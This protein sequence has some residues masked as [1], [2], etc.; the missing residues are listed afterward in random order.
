MNSHKLIICCLIL[1]AASISVWSQNIIRGPY[2]Q[3]G[4]STS[5]T[6]KWRTDAATNSKI[7]YGAI[8][9]QL[10]DSLSQD[11]K[12]VDHELVLSGLIP[13]TKY[14]YAVGD[15]SGQMVGNDAEHSFI[16]AP[17]TGAEQFMRLWVLG[18]CGT[19]DEKQRAVRD[20]YYNYVGEEHTD[21]ILLLGDNAYPDGKDKEYQKA[22]FEDMY[23][24]KL[25]NTHLWSCPGNHDYRS[26][27]A[28]DQSGPYFDIFS[29]PTNAEAGGLASGTEAY[30]SFDYG[31]LHVVSLD[32]HDSGRDPGDPM[33]VWL[34][35]DLAATN[36]TWIIVIF[37]HPPYSKGS[38][39]SDAEN[40]L[41]DMRENV[42]PIL[43]DYGVDLVLNGHSHG[44]E[45]SKLINGHYGKSSTYDPAL[46]DVD[47]GNGRIEGTG[48]YF[49]DPN[50]ENPNLGAVYTVT[51]SAGKLSRGS[52]D[53]P[54]MVENI[55]ELGSSIIEIEKN[56]LD[57]KFL[58]S[59][60]AV[61]DYFTI[62]KSYNGE[63]PSAS[64]VSPGSGTRF[65][66]PQ[67]ISIEA[68]ANDTDG[69]V[70]QVDFF[71]DGASVGVDSV[72]P[73]AV[74]WLIPEN[75]NYILSVKATDDSG[76][77]SASVPVVITVG[78]ALVN[79]QVAADS[80]D[81][82]E[83]KPD[84]DVSLSSSD[85]ELARDNGN[86]GRDQIVGVRFNQ[87]SVPQGATIVKAH[88]QFTV[89]EKS[90]GVSSID[91]SG[92]A[93]DNAKT[94][95][96][97]AFNISSRPQ[98]AASV[99][100]VISDW[101]STNEAGTDQQSP[102]LSSIVQEIV[103]RPGWLSGA[104]M[105]FFLEGTGT[106]TAESY[107]GSK[108]EAPVL[109]IEYIPALSVDVSQLNHISCPG[110]NNGGAVASVSGGAWPYLYQW[111]DGSSQRA[112]NNLA[113]GD[114]TLMVIDAMND[115]ASIS[116][117]IKEG[118]KLSA[119]ITGADVSC[120]GNADGVAA[121][122]VSGGN[123]PYTYAWSNGETQANLSGLTAGTYALTL[124]DAGGCTDVQSVVINQ[125]SALR[126]AI[127][128]T[129][130][131]CFGNANGAADVLTSGGSAP[132][133]YIWSNGLDSAN[134]DGLAAG[135]YRLTVEDAKG[136]LFTDSVSIAQPSELSASIAA[137]DLSCFENSDGRAVASINGGTAPYNYHWSN[138]GR[139]RENNALAA[140]SYRLSIIDANGCALIDSVNIQQPTPLI[141]SSESFTVR[142]YGGADGSAA[143]SVSGGTAPYTYQWSNGAQ[144]PEISGL[145]A[146]LYTFTATDANGCVFVKTVD[147]PQ[148][149]KLAAIATAVDVA[150]FGNLQ[151][152]ATVFAS[153]GV[154]PYTYAWENGTTNA[155]ISELAAGTY[156]FTL[157]DARNCV[158][159]DSAVIKQPTPLSASI[160]TKDVSCYENSDGSASTLALGGTAP[161]T[162]AWSNGSQT[163]EISSLKAGLYTFTTTDANGCVA[164]NSVTI[165][166]PEI[167]NTAINGFD[168]R[169]FE[170]ASGEAA[171]EVFGGTAPFAYA[172]NN[173]AET[174]QVSELT[175]GYHLLT[176]TDANGCLIVDSIFINQP[177]PIS[178]STNTSDASC[179]GAANGEAQ[180]F[181]SG[182]LGAYAYAWS[183]GK[184]V[185]NLSG[186]TA[187]G[188]ALTVVDANG[189]NA[190][191]SLEINQPAALS[192]LANTTE[193]SCFGNADGFTEVNASGGTGPYAYSW[194]N[195][196]QT[197]NL[198]E[199]SA[200]TY[201]FTIADALGCTLVDSIEVKQ[202]AMLSANLQQIDV[203]CFGASDGRAF[204]AATGGTPPYDYAWNTGKTEGNISN[205]KAGV[206]TLS[207]TDANG[208]LSIDSIII[209]QPEIF[210][211]FTDGVNL[212]CNS[213]SDGTASASVQGGTP[214]YSYRWNNGADNLNIS[215]LPAGTYEVTATD[216]N[217]CQSINSVTLLAPAPLTFHTEAIDLS[218]YESADGSIKT[219]VAGGTPPYT[220]NWSNGASE[221]DLTGLAAGTYEFSL[222]D[223]NTCQVEGA[224]T[225]SQ[226]T[227]IR[228]EL[229]ASGVISGK[230]N[231]WAH[232][233]TSGGLE[234]YAYLWDNGDTTAETSGL[235][236]GIHS[237]TIT[238]ANSCSSEHFVTVNEIPAN[239]AWRQVDRQNFEQETGIWQD[240]L[241]NDL[242]ANS[243]SFSMQISSHLA[244]PVMKTS[245]LNLAAYEE[246]KISF[247]YMTEG[248]DHSEDVFW[249][250]I[251]SDG[252][253]SFT[254]LKK[255]SW[256]DEFNNRERM[257]DHLVVP[258]PFTIKTVIRFQSKAAG[259][260]NS[261]YIDDVL[262]EGCYNPAKDF[263]P[264]D[265]NRPLVSEG[266]H[267]SAPIP[268]TS[269]FDSQMV[270]FPNPVK[271]QL[272]VWLKARV[273][274]K[275]KPFYLSVYNLEGRSVLQESFPAADNKWMERR[276]DVGRLSSGFYFISVNTGTEVLT[277]R[278]VK[279]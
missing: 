160:N 211:V 5:V 83:N 231:A 102:D 86:S 91:I 141:A 142:C 180:V 74:D 198:S 41:I 269:Q 253:V 233:S 97:E 241:R 161:Y 66:T 177:D 149:E 216:A 17:L 220:Y 42:L 124:T 64:I 250:Q 178:I 112:T 40:K 165:E 185:A 252:G 68:T 234:P 47:G 88:I 31:N 84:G 98:T 239:C 155:S 105:A 181:V 22:L 201:P 115:T 3:S 87:L 166:Q 151:G 30:Y 48:A 264:I 173:G 244:N 158:F 33:L 73:Y 192:V 28:Q 53:H 262:I 90:I 259:Q 249:L 35:N 212:N 191:A 127:S 197:N 251:S 167:L 182:G 243:G 4:S 135:T 199:L 223:A 187:G 18:D 245:S 136:C 271:S 130:A 61:R 7:W 111:S 80:D 101:N 92:E 279:R 188:Y 36:Q 193:A 54:I 139:S 203:S 96:N 170:D 207:L 59:E 153:G 132:Y 144:T 236:A 99:N 21:L 79:R 247:S 1:L 32:S 34:E 123:A 218:C 131:A 16:S 152:A 225:L 175:A 189:C 69:E 134:I 100:W 65:Q 118:E 113:G 126:T 27:S 205:L 150:C 217:G 2:L 277:K 202:A 179:F 58:N 183:N 133:N 186:L 62:L 37:H 260:N 81:A 11:A 116:F 172:W 56:Q 194:N 164:V 248:M 10:S 270:V 237:L 274:L 147:V 110:R 85:L 114:Y 104:S 246:L 209:Q 94:F 174:A 57:L 71:V 129:D 121:V 157:T 145:T 176:V 109:F 51:G 67:S 276:L 258:G 148:P 106:R 25:I 272:N 255:W 76:N 82:E 19:A 72:G 89:D 267:V 103:N 228:A 78:N 50:G 46:H 195:G 190:S 268:D 261:L 128:G 14:Y 49:K 273:F 154:G 125:P 93:T 213:A 20:A 43:E 184:N 159:I 235:S 39:D 200:G 263:A 60:G 221:S 107:D 6:I 232:A 275:D 224:V 265:P 108:S 137:D 208:C 169:C 146:G 44:Y 138:G 26:A 242:N 55:V 29:F 215:N 12:V 117:T 122:S 95:S 238:D 24:D 23:E 266:T 227:Q 219:L 226:P 119:A 38:H 70:I 256:G 171:A 8:A 120:N 204:V 75:G 168:L 210:A 206:Y 15:A 222:S 77:I 230:D 163:S 240:G 9:G 13:N 143:V 162:Y 254:T 52:F 196:A 63:R 257:F 140:G 156:S 214:P 45:R 229:N 278:F